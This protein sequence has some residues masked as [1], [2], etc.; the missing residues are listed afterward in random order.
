MEELQDLGEGGVRVLAHQQITAREQRGIGNQQ[1][2]R[3]GSSRRLQVPAVVVER[4]VLLTRFLERLDAPDA[5]ARVPDHGAADVGG[6]FPEGEG[7][8]DLVSSAG[9]DPCAKMRFAFASG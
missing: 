3:L 5:A 4:Q 6:K 2:P 9:A 1:R 8:H 7:A